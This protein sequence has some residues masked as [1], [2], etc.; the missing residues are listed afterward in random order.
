MVIERA[1]VSS[2]ARSF[3]VPEK[4]T[5]VDFSCTITKE[6][7]TNVEKEF[8]S[9]ML[10]YGTQLVSELYVFLNYVFQFFFT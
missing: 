9:S 7:L 10:N 8:S 4:Q 5:K 6:N 3:F 2:Q 1:P